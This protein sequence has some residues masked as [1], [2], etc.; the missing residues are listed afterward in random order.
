MKKITFKLGQ[1]PDKNIPF[2]FREYQKILK[3]VCYKMFHLVQSRIKISKIF[4]IKTE[5]VHVCRYLNWY[6]KLKIVCSCT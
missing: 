6:T 2:S 1:I 5:Y 4:Q 3:S